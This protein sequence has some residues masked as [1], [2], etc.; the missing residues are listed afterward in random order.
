MI[1]L[2]AN[3]LPSLPMV[4]QKEAQGKDGKE[5]IAHHRE[6]DHRRG[7]QGWDY[8]REEYVLGR[9]SRVSFETVTCGEVI[10]RVRMQSLND[11]RE[12]A[13]VKKEVDI[14]HGENESRQRQSVPLASQELSVPQDTPGKT[15]GSLERCSLK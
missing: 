15:D 10:R 5:H 6:R 2:D 1:G 14:T 12:G 13:L 9:V 7:L 3:R 8:S 4:S 11:E